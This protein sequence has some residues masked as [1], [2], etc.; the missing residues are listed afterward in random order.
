VARLGRFAQQQLR[1][2]PGAISDKS[3]VKQVLTDLV[4]RLAPGATAN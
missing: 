2:L 4:K 3:L 1:P